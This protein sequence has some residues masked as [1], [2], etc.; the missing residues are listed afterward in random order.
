MKCF[1]A[2]QSWDGKST[3]RHGAIY[4]PEIQ[5]R[6][7]KRIWGLSTTRA[8]PAGSGAIRIERT[9]E[10]IVFSVSNFTC[11]S[12]FQPFRLKWRL[13]RLLDPCCFTRKA[14]GE[15]R[16][17]W[18]F[19]FTSSQEMWLFDSFILFMGQTS[20]LAFAPPFEAFVSSTDTSPGLE[21]DG[22]RSPQFGTVA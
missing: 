18:T 9:S 4:W 2:N 13:C 14:L 12:E 21:L 7:K 11:L 17:A 10:I 1:S 5:I 8:V 6:E 20:Q 16:K 3:S 22:H 19:M 15:R